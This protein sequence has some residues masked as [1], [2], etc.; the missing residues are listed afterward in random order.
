MMAGLSIQPCPPATI[1][2]VK[3]V[4]A[5]AYEDPRGYFSEVFK[6]SDFDGAGLEFTIRQVSQSF[7]VH[8]GT[9]RGLH[10]QMPP[11]SQAKLVRVLRGAVYDAAVDIRVG[12]PTYGQ[13]VSST[14]TAENRKQLFIPRGFAHG[15]FTLEADTLVVYA[16]DNEYAP[17]HEGG[18]CWNDHD[19]GIPWPDVGSEVV[20][21][22]KDRR[23]P[24]LADVH[25]SFY[26]QG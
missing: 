16:V 12:S 19:L 14:L 3:V 26:Y 23:Q 9:M 6:Q 5:P 21:S 25:Q 22:E 24:P 8:P 10:F 11:H 15:F 1:P 13:W 18:I 17:G 4:E 2:D 7:S 20:L